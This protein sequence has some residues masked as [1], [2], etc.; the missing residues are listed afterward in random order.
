MKQSCSYAKYSVCQ[1]QIALDIYKM[2]EIMG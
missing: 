1:H 2:A